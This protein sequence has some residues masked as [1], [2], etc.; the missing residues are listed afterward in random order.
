MEVS[1]LPQADLSAP[2]PETAAGSTAGSATV[3]QTSTSVDTESS[4][5]AGVISA[6]DFA[7]IRPLDIVAAL[8]IL[9]AEVRAG[10]DASLEGP[11]EFSVAA[12]NVA[13]QNATTQNAAI[14][15]PIVQNSIAQNPVAQNPTQAAQE[16]IDMVLRALPE[17]ASDALAWTAALIQVEAAVQS[18][19]ERAISV[20]TAWRDTPPPVVDAAKETRALFLEALG[21][22]AQNPLWLRPEWMGL[23]APFHRFRRR[24][25]NARRRLT[26][27]DYPL[28]N[29]DESEEFRR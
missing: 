26:D 23:G 4:S 13:T 5:T 12:R 25:R 8:Q 10:L 27:P 19:L 22:E 3:A 21:D 24:R 18:G 28:V 2:R 29:L 16:L 1:K 17:D 7:D 9:V 14:Q 20:V 11:M 6:S 15:N